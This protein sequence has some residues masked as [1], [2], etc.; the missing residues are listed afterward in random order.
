MVLSII[1]D[2]VGVEYVSF[3]NTTCTKFRPSHWNWMIL[4]LD[5]ILDTHHSTF[6]KTDGMLFVTFRIVLMG[7]KD[8]SWTCEFIDSCRNLFVQYL[9]PRRYKVSLHVIFHL[10]IIIITSHSLYLKYSGYS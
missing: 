8:K 4:Y 2:Q 10:F 5:N 6:T 1:I 3:H 7:E 9:N